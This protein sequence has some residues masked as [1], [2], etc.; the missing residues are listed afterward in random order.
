MAVGL[1]A[2]RGLM[3]EPQGVKL[4]RQKRTVQERSDAGWST[5]HGLFKDFW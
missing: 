1:T 4:L 3:L 5:V 2:V